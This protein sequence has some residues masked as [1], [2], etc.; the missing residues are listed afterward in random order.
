[1]NHH[2]VFKLPVP[3]Q[4]QAESSLPIEELKNILQLIPLTGEGSLLGHVL[5]QR[6]EGNN[7]NVNNWIGHLTTG[8]VYFWHYQRLDLISIK[9]S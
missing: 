7:D 6:G 3:L 8:S 4:C 9:L 2:N 1:M 5:Q